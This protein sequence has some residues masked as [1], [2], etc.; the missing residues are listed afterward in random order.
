MALYLRRKLD[1][2]AEIAVWQVTETEEELLDLQEE[3]MDRFGDIPT[4]VNQLLNI[5]FVKA[6]CHNVYI[7]SLVQRGYEVK[8]LFYPQAK[9]NMVKLPELVKKWEPALKF[10][11]ETPPYF[12]FQLPKPRGKAA[13]AKPEVHSM[14][15]QIKQLLYD[16]AELLLEK[17]E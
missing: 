10:K 17:K 6:L 2:K 1:N 7:T 8:F 15:E 11:V 3:L 5:A 4:S 13:P 14:F 12:V 16:C 9:L